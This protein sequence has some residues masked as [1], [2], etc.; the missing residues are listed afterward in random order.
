MKRRLNLAAALIH[1]PEL[2]L[3]DEPE[4]HLREHRGT[5]ARCCSVSGSSPSASARVS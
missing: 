5:R 2:I 1:A 3:L 4:R